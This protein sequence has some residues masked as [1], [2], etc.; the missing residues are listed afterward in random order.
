MTIDKKLEDGKLTMVIVG[1]ID[2]N[3]SPDLEAALE[4]D[5]VTEIVFDFAGVE[6]ISSAGLRVLMT[7]Q[8]AMMACGGTMKVRSPNAMV[9]GVFEITGLGDIFNVE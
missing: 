3:T 5:G 1:R 6:Y 7:A 4:L 9:R 8:K 2:T